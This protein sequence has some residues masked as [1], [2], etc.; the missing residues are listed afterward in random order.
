MKRKDL[1]LVIDMQNVYTE[2]QEWA[3]R[4][5]E[6]VIGNIIRLL[7]GCTWENVMFTRFL[8]AEQPV[9]IWKE[10]NKKNAHI[11]ADTWLNEM[12]PEL[13]PWMEKYPLLT[14]SVYSSFSIPEVKA[15]ARRADYVI[16]TGVVAECCVLST[17]LAGIDEGCKIIYLKDAVSG[18]S[19]EAEQYTER[20]VSCF[21]PLHA[22]IMTV[23]EYMA[24]YGL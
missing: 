23:K 10:Y 21:A 8:A 20:I 17:V 4:D 3:C 2:N 24:A 12:I 15:A 18:L 9:G 19:A 14:K 22:E 11:N 7:Q 1:L 6:G 13:L 5:M 16:I